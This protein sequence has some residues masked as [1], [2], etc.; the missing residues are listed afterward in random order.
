MKIS[1]KFMFILGG[2]LILSFISLGVTEISVQEIR[3]DFNRQQNKNTPIML[4]VL[5]LQKNVIQIQ[6]WLTDISATK[7]K[8]GFD[9]GFSEA[10]QYKQ[11][12]E[13]N[14]MELQQ[15]GISATTIEALSQKL[16]QYYEVGVQMANTYIQE[17][18]DKG[19]EF[20]EKF[21]PYAEALNEDIGKLSEEAASSFS[22]SVKEIERKIAKLRLTLIVI[23]V[24]VLVVALLS[25]GVV[26]K[27]LKPIGYMTKVA[28]EKAG[29]NF[30]ADESKERIKYA[31]QKDEI[32]GML[33]ALQEMDE[34][35]RQ[36][37]KEGHETTHA[38]FSSAENLQKSAQ[39][40]AQI[41]KEVDR[42]MNEV[43]ISISEQAK[44]VENGSNEIERLKIA[45]QN[46]SAG[47]GR[48]E[49]LIDEM[50]RLKEEGTSLLQGTVSKSEQNNQAADKI[51]AVVTATDKSTKEIQASSVMI[52]NI[53]AQTN[54]LALN[55]AIE[56][57]RAGE[58]GKG[59]AVVAEEIRKLA[60]ESNQLTE[61]IESVIGTL[62]H[63][64]EA[65]V[66][67]VEMVMHLSKEQLKNIKKTQEKFT[68]IDDS[69]KSVASE[70]IHL[71]QA[72]QE[73]DLAKENLTAAVGHISAIAQENAASSEE[74][75]ASIEEQ[76]A[77]IH[78]VAKEGE[79]L[80]SLAQ[81]LDAML[82]N[83][84]I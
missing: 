22:G 51:L 10:E 44:D 83:F 1:T 9:D 32:G 81:K 14:L 6:Q 62:S 73:I 34:S 55:A 53:A 19:N 37:M 2:I 46:E 52:K 58:A 17:G 78:E 28:H 41:A 60:E 66:E 76:T 74:I 65:A 57:A 25:Y 38:V 59:F 70:V 8:P 54:L 45:I 63:E 11:K 67:T 12:A 80:F 23:I 4:S 18:T 39:S 30:R 29:L 48:L 7:G 50:I 26:R 31:K 84:K 40:A 42:A 33:K 24:L 64:T 27:T 35:I 56:S 3:D 71:K 13:E 77:G 5:E 61:E 43:A 72:G 16:Q 20:M 79:G 47:M 21:D 69:I 75:A 36:F 15:L 82:Q 49:S 68:G